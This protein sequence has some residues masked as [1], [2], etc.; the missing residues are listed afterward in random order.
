MVEELRQSGF[1]PGGGLSLSMF[2]GLWGLQREGSRLGG[3]LDLVLRAV[4]LSR[5]DRK[6]SW[7]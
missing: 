5:G 3:N 1:Y 7:D 2:R 6:C 4:G